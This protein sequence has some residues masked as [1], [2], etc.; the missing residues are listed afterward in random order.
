M[1]VNGRVISIKSVADM[2]MQNPMMKDISWEFIV[3][4]A[5]EC[6]RIVGTAPM[7]I[8]EQEVVEDTISNVDYPKVEEATSIELD[9]PN[10][11]ES[12]W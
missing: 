7:F 6:M 1:A 9:T 12:Q 4:H 10:G 3:S 11:V 2:L 5:V 8:S